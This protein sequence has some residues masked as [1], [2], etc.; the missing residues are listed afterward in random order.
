MYYEEKIINGV[1]MWRSSTNGAWTQCS[2]TDMSQRIVDM[3]E[4]ITRLKANLAEVGGQEAGVLIT[5]FLLFVQQ[6]SISLCHMF[7]GDDPQALTGEEIIDIKNE[8]N[9]KL[10]DKLDNHPAPAKVA[11]DVAKDAER[12]RFLRDED[13]WGCDNDD[14]TESRWADLGELHAGE[15]DDFVDEAMLKSQGGE[16]VKY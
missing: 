6:Q 12:Y 7:I 15:F 1:L 3:K 8:F 2:I 4:E 10:G 14:E 11:D 9:K 5:Q 13:S 16:S